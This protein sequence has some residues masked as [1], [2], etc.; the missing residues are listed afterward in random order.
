[1]ALIVAPYVSRL[2][3]IATVSSSLFAPP[4][5]V[6]PRSLETRRRLAAP[7]YPVVGAKLSPFR[8]V[9]MA[10]CVPVNVI[11]AVPLAPAVKVSP[12]VVDSVDVPLVLITWSWIGLDAASES[13]TDRALLFAVE[14]TFTVLLMVDW[15][16]GTVF[17]GARLVGITVITKVWLGLVARPPPPPLS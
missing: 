10:V 9:L 11:V 13:A 14:N 6:F 7:L 3:V 12:E 2:T 4:G 8:A 17:T 16:P 1:M 5:P 15:L